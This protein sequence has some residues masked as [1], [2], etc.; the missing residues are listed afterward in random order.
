MNQKNAEVMKLK[1][2]IENI[3]KER[4][5]LNEEKSWTQISKR[6]SVIH[7]IMYDYILKREFIPSTPTIMNLNTNGERNG[8][9]SSCFI[10]GITDSIDGI[11]ES[12]HEAAVVTKATGGVGYDWSK[13]RGSNENVKSISANSGG[14]MSFIGIFDA[15]LDG[16]RQGGKRRGAGMS[17]LSIYHP[18]ILKFIEAKALVKKKKRDDDDSDEKYSR[19]NFSVRPDNKFYET[20]DKTPDKL[21]KTKNVVDGKENVLKDSSGKEY[22]YKMLWDKI[23]HNAWD[24]AEPGIFNGEIALDRCTCKHISTEVYSNPCAEYVHIPYTSCNLGSINLSQVVDVDNKTVNWKKLE[25]IT[26]EAT[27]YLNGIIDNNKYPVQ[28]IHDETHAVRPIG[29]GMM[30]LAHL[31]YKL[32]LPYDS[33][34]A[35]E[36][37]RNISKFITLVSMRR[38]MEMAKKLG[39]T[40]KYYDYNVFMDANKRFFTENTFMG[41]DVVKLKADIKKYGVYN[42]CFTSIAPT[43]TISFIADTS[44]GMEPV[45]GLVFTRK[46]EKENKT[47]EYVY[48]VDPVFEEYLTNR[49]IIN[50]VGPDALKSH[51][52][53]IYAYISTHNGSCQGCPLL[54]KEEQEAFKVAGDI[55]PMGHLKVLAEVA[56]NVSLSVSKTINLPKNCSEKEL[57]DVFLKAQS[58]GIIGVTVYRDGSR[59]GILVHENKNKFVISKTNAPRRPAVVRGELHLFTIG[60]HKYY[61]AVG[62]DDDNNLFE[63]F[64]G[65]NEDKKDVVFTEPQK[66]IIKKLKRG[67]YIFIGEDK[68]KFSLTNGHSDDS[69]DGMTRLLS[70]GLRHGGDIAFGVHQ[71]EKTSGPML[72]FSKV[73]ARTLKKYIENNTPVSGEVCPSCGGNLHRLEGCITCSTCGWSKCS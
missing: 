56:N 14:V 31:F 40:Y 17:M 66:G 53:L 49:A 44:S 43:G 62:L 47:Y 5:Y 59:K 29:L 61:T 37:T 18:D 15:V 68:E 72:S 10:L 6:L 70:F 27:V 71:L 16:V 69:A 48:I 20:L 1:P 26:E 22:T 42:S 8:T 12:M 46:I 39:K 13:L 57:G 3:L 11:M 36:L 28:K 4:Y 32:G 58:L 2:H 73:L 41:I 25:T 67:D 24:F 9:L 54:T 38:S 51:T 64:T 19:S 30:G 60:K 34:N 55:T 50:K 52:E 7:P 23:I 21:F 35:C 65:F 45:F 63:V 33:D